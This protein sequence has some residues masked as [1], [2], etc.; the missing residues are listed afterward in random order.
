MEWHIKCD[1][2]EISRYVFC[3]GDQQR[4]KKIAEHFDSSSLVTESRGYLVFSGKYKGVHMTVCGTGM[5]G[6]AVAI[7]LE[8]LA[9]MGADT[10]IRV[11]SCGVFQEGQKPGDIIVASGTVRAGGTCNAY[12]PP[13]YP[14]VPTFAV[15]RALIEASEEL[16]IPVTVGVG[17]AG[18]AFYAPP[19]NAES[20]QMKAAGLV[21][22]EMESDTLFIVG[23]LRHWRTGALFTSDGTPSVTKPD[24]GEKDFRR[25]ELDS[26]KV[27][28][29]AM[30]KIAQEDRKK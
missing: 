12:L 11:G 27:A 18:D 1:A 8:E 6:P 17:V 21:S 4:A 13:I 3:P 9:H 7:G 26:I 2:K 19:D 30:W 25:G 29:H 24:W 22:I 10:F 20:E 5:G 28:L 14:A 15:L 23:L 16:N